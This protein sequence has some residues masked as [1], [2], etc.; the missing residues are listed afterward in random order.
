MTW[1]VVNIIFSSILSGV[2]YRMGG[3]D[4]YNTKFRDFG[5]P[6]MM[7]VVMLLLTGITHWLSLLFSFLLL[8]GSLTTYWKK[9]EADAY[10]YN[11][12]FT[13]LGYSLAML[14]FVI[15]DKCWLGFLVRSIVLTGLIV[16]WSE[17]QK[18]AVEEEFGRGFVIIITLPLLL[19]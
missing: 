14:P 2:L 7:Y 17:T 5:V 12:L 18:D 11:W 4:L 16:F 6:L 3:S 9:K 1:K 15:A 13:G 19:I 10:W 8:F